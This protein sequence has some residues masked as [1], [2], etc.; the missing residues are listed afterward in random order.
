V[1]IHCLKPAGGQ[2]PT[3]CVPGTPKHP[4][5]SSKSHISCARHCGTC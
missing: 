5:N 2:P 1:T 3:A 4:E